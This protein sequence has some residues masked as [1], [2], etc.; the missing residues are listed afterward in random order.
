[1]KNNRL[2]RKIISFWF[3]QFSQNQNVNHLTKIVVGIESDVAEILFHNEKK[4]KQN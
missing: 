4:P 2:E 1:M 3:L